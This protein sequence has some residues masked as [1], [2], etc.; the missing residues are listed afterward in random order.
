MLC[1]KYGNNYVTL[2]YILH[3]KQQYLQEGFNEII[4]SLNYLISLLRHW[5]T[6]WDVFSN[7]I[8]FLSVLKDWTSVSNITI[9]CNT[10]HIKWHVRTGHIASNSII[11]WL[12]YIIWHVSLDVGYCII[13]VKLCC[14]IM[15]WYKL[16]MCVLHSHIITFHSLIL[17][18]YCGVVLLYYEVIHI[19]NVTLTYY[20]IPQ[21]NIISVIQ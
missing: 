6:K 8:I 19:R 17:S 21:F 4:T 1:F 14:G 12:H 2:F 7:Y 9:L 3:V 5:I 16:E 18:V 13:E 10:F 11:I 20:N 15:R